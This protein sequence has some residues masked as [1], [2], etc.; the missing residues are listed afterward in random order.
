[1]SEEKKIESADDAG[2][3]ENLVSDNPSNPN[4]LGGDDLGKEEGKLSEAGKNEVNM[5]DYIEKSQY[6]EAEKKIS[7]QGEELGKNR[8]FLKEI[9]PLL[10]KL[11]DRPEIIEAIVDGKIDATLAQAAL[12]GKINISDANEVNQAHKEIKK[13]LGKKEYE[14][15]SS[16]EIEKMVADKV[17]STLTEKTKKLE[18]MITKSDSRREYEDKV[19]VFIKNT[20][21]YGKYAKDINTWLE[22]HPDQYDISIAYEAVKGREVISAASKEEEIKAAEAAKELAGNASGGSSQGGKVSEDKDLADQ[23]IAGKGNPNNF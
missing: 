10:D 8:K 6:T 5:D 4:D 16:E 21:D 19:N 11:R 20:S 23:L 7:E 22:E 12:D 17:E 15:T 3:S 18:G 1:M 14:K 13:D 9:S 2:N